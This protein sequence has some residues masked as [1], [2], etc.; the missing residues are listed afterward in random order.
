MVVLYLLA[1][2]LFALVHLLV[3]WRVARLEKRYARLAAD[4]DKLLKQSCVRAGNSNRPDP[5]LAAKQQHELALVALKRDRVEN[6][7][8]S[9]QKFSERFG[10]FRRGVAGYRGRALPYLFG[11][12]DVTA[13]VLV[14]NQ[15]EVG[16]SQVR[17]LVGM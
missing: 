7:Y 8:V 11:L 13:A 9:R 16:V 1:R 6:R 12:V 2:S 4:A 3:R 17:S 14:L 5:F 10:A 15:F